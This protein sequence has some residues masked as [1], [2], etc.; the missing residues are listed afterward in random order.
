MTPLGS[1]FKNFLEP[2]SF[3]LYATLFFL[4]YR[5]DKDFI[6][7]VLFIHYLFGTILLSLASIKAMDIDNQA[8]NNWLYN[9]L[10]LSTIC[11]LSVYFYS[12]L[13][14]TLKKNIIVFLL[15]INIIIFVDYDL[16]K[17]HFFNEFNGY[18]FAVCFLSIVIYTL[19]YFDQLIRNVNESNI[20]YRFDFWLISGY[21]LYF[22]SCFFI[23][24]FYES[25]DPEERGYLWAVQNVI[26]FISSAITCAGY[27]WS[28]YK[29]RIS[30]VV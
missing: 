24:L 23:I 7:L 6:H 1:L 4:K 5:K 16:L 11:V 18:V 2:L 28:G 17:G 8:D 19:F 12:L 10:Y 20:L 29:K 25:G 3:L 14:T 13:F 22:L 27:L 30:H 26:L 15:A 21:L 9:I